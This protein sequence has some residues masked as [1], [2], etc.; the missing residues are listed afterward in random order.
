MP[1]RTVVSLPPYVHRPYEVFVNGVL[2]SEGTDFQVVGSSL[3]FERSFV[4]APRL[5]FWRWIFILTI[6]LVVG[7]YE[8]HDTIDVVY[9][10]DGRRS[11]ASLKP[12][13][14][15]T[16][17]TSPAARDGRSG[18]SRSRSAPS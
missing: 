6:G 4:P 15:E 14:S 5:A 1:D 11:V 16:D 3:M 8:P 12:P 2:Q 17:R 13:L 18:R 10:L 7:G 9:S